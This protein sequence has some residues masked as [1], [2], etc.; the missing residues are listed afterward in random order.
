M[1]FKIG[2]IVKPQ[3]NASYAHQTMSLDKDKLYTVKRVDSRTGSVLL[4]VTVGSYPLK[5]YYYPVWRFEDR[6]FNN[7]TPLEH[8]VWGIE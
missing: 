6:T 3:E 7:I 4:D 1:T 5:N 8:I 2:D